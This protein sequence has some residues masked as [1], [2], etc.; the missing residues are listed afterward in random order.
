MVALSLVL[1]LADQLAKAMA[2]CLAVRW[3][4]AMASC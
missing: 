3:E 2:S 4:R 1:Y